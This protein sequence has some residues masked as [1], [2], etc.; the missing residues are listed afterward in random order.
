METMSQKLGAY[1]STLS[2][3]ELAP[4]VVHKAKALIL[5]TIG[6]GFGGYGSEPAKIARELAATVTSTRPATIMCSGEKTSAELAAFANDVMMR[7][8]DYND[9]YIT[10]GSGHPS[11]SIAALLAAGELTRTSG[12]ELIVGT[13]VAYEVFCRICDAWDNKKIGI[14]HATVGAIASAAGAA[15][16]L[17]LTREQIV[18]AINL[19]VAGNVALN[20]TR[21]GRVS[22]WKACGYANANRNALFACDL[23]AR[24]MTGPDEVFEGR[25]GFFNVVSR[26]TF[27]L[28]PLGGAGRPFGI[29]QAHIKQFPLGNFS[30]T[31]VTAALQ[32][33][34]EGLDVDAVE[35]IHIRTGTKAL[36][37]MAD[38]PDKWRPPN[39][40]TADH[41]IPYTAGVALRH[42]TIDA[43]YFG[44]DYLRDEQ[45][46]GLI[47]RIECGVSEEADRRAAEMNLCELELVMRSGERKTTRIEY[48]RGHWRNPMS[49]A[50]IET[51][52]RSLAGGMLER[53][54]ADALIGHVWKLDEAPDVASLIQLTIS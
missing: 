9:G 47:A 1:A 35:Q 44:E 28:P 41:S 26:G 53:A 51:K 12:R 34:S 24:G 8:L 46:L 23:A 2:F 7:Y 5:D 13:V 18:E 25:D 43:K 50:E 16:L 10:H 42:G 32:A 33:R 27:E 52:F 20:Q 45:L 54:Q 40:E 38:G 30:Q 14:D 19:T 21:A 22:A 31:V 17:G 39:R 48:H 3:E 11:D 37:V 49:D 4:E 29:M 36:R 6:C 15:R